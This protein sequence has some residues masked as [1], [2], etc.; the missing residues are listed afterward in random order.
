M[1]S[2]KSQV[3]P[4]PPG[5]PRS[6]R[7]PRRPQFRN[8]RQPP[9][10][11]LNG[12]RFRRPGAEEFF[13]RGRPPISPDV[14]LGHAGIEI[15]DDIR[16][17][18][19]AGDLSKDD[20]AVGDGDRSSQRRQVVAGKRVAMTL[21]FRR[22]QLAALFQF[23][24]FPL[25]GP[26]PS[27]FRLVS[28]SRRLDIGPSAPEV[29]IGSERNVPYSE[30]AVPARERHLAQFVD[31]GFRVWRADSKT[32]LAELKIWAVD[33][34]EGKKSRPLASAWASASA[35]S[36]ASHRPMRRGAVRPGTNQ[37]LRASL[38]RARG[39]RFRNCSMVILS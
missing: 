30:I 10:G 8:R 38:Q 11:A 21:S 29:L 18:Q 31:D 3:R 2:F 19:F 34:I 20:N 37:A 15:R 16:V 1:S 24:P 23:R 39:K 32:C 28:A 26:A 14:I 6:C 36:S 35:S 5:F 7:A 4:T 17:G 33:R 9:L 22:A 12:R 27:L 25:L 13:E